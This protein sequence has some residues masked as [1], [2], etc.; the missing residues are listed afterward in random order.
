MADNFYPYEL[1][2]GD[3]WSTTEPQIFGELVDLAEMTPSH[4][5]EPWQGEFDYVIA[6]CPGSVCALTCHPQRIA[7]RARITMLERRID[8]TGAT[9]RP[10]KIKAS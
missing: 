7:W 1:R 9:A 6:N 2:Q 3:Q 4:V 5:M 8:R 10:A